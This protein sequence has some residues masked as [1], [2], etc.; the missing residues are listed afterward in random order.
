MNNK[1]RRFFA[2]YQL[3]YGVLGITYNSY[4]LFKAVSSDLQQALI[5]LLLM[6]HTTLTLTAGYYVLRAQKSWFVMTLIAQA[7]QILPS[8][9]KNLYISFRCGVSYNFLLASGT[10]NINLLDL[11]SAFN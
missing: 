3:L 8:S 2:V 11:N 7:L 10:F 5:T 4:F 1:P 9:S 6:L